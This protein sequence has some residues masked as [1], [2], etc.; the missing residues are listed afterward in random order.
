MGIP[1]K[2]AAAKPA[3]YDQFPH[4]SP[5]AHPVGKTTRFDFLVS[6]QYNAHMDKAFG[7]SR[8]S[9]VDSHLCSGSLVDRHTVVTSAQCCTA[10]VSGVG[11]LK[12]MRQNMKVLV[13][14]TGNTQQLFGVKSIE[15]FNRFGFNPKD[16]DRTQYD[17]CK[18]TLVK[19]VPR[20]LA[21]PVRADGLELRLDS[22]ATRELA[23]EVGSNLIYAGFRASGETPTTSNSSHIKVT[24]PRTLQATQLNVPL[25]SHEECNAPK[26]HN[27]RLTKSVYCVSAN[28]D[29]SVRMLQPDCQ[30]DLGGPLLHDDG[31]TFT[32]VGIRSSG[33]CKLDHP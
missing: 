15:V 8:A 24:G 28:V 6:L 17:I 4:M 22:N 27:G 32:L 10:H 25:S 16:T 5:N 33:N 7:P 18:V 23:L 13:G 12:T 1:G 3:P 30:G 9:T 21:K 11:G 19:D 26:S 14:A 20:S 2:K 29:V 31:K